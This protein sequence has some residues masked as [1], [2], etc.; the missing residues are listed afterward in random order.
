MNNLPQCHYSKGSRSEEC[1]GPL[2]GSLDHLC[3]LPLIQLEAAL[4]HGDLAH[5]G[6][7]VDRALGVADVQAW[8][9]GVLQPT[10]TDI[11]TLEEKS[12][13][14]SSSPLSFQLS[15]SETNEEIC[16]GWLCQAEERKL[17]HL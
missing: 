17:A 6:R 2:G 4:P 16:N 7:Q 13:K 8:S 5:L 11:K 10:G 15:C 1:L 14:A 9:L 12:C 3:R